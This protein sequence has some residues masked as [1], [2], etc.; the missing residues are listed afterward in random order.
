MSLAE[1]TEA[2]GESPA[3]EL[4]SLIDERVG[5]DRAG[6][7]RA[8]AGA[9]LRRLSGD[10]SE[11]I[12][13]EDLVAEV[14]SVFEFSSA[15]GDEPVAVRAFNPTRE[16]HGYE[17]LGSVLETNSDD[18][19]FLVDS[20]NGELESRGLAVSRL[21]HPIVGVERDGDGRIVGC[22]RAREAPRRE[23]VMHYDLA[24]RLDDE[25]LAELE[26]AVRDVLLAV[27]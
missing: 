6:A 14:V 16:E 23:S 13:P 26:A 17:P 12:K 19:P 21:L 22:G 5:A 15:R 4:L 11:G 2:G 7:V 1:E 9:Y 8:F 3:S 18:Y 25:Q 24:E 10:A 27:R 20:V